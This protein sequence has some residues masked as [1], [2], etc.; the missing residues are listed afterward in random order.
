[1]REEGWSFTIERG[2]QWGSNKSHN[3]ILPIVD[4]KDAR[5]QR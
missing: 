1:M 3:D 2:F 4:G 5:D